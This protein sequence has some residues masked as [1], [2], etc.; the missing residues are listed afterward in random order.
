ME[1]PLATV[2]TSDSVA[3][4][5]AGITAPCHACDR[6][7]RKIRNQQHGRLL[8]DDDP[9]EYEAGEVEEYEGG[10]ADNGVDDAYGDNGYETP[11]DPYDNDDDEGD[12]GDEGGFTVAPVD[13]PVIP[14]DAPADGGSGIPAPD[15]ADEAAA[16]TD[17]A[18]EEPASG[19]DGTDAAAGD[20]APVDGTTTDTGVAT[21]TA[22]GVAV[23]ADGTTAT[24][25]GVDA[26]DTGSTGTFE[27]TPDSGGT[28]ATSSIPAESAP[29]TFE[30]PSTAG[31]PGETSGT[32]A[33]D[34]PT[35]E[36]PAPDTDA[37]INSTDSTDGSSGSTVL[38][39]D[40][41]GTDTT[42]DGTDTT[43]RSS[44]SPRGT[45]GQPPGDVTPTA[46][47]GSGDASADASGSVPQ[48]SNT[49]GDNSTVYAV[50]GTVVAVILVMATL[51]G[52]TVYRRYRKQRWSTSVVNKPVRSPQH[53]AL[54]HP[55][56]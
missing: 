55:I 33:T 40:A 16:G 18:G 32:P 27:G 2:T 47:P 24:D 8:L 11:D 54:R 41:T 38:P 48:V 10:E 17:P 20:A 28:E 45:A 42:Q 49:G 1:F 19:A 3:D 9:E 22:A 37:P 5:T 43:D 30:G 14:P 4:T 56:M 31:V 53:N 35:S 39:D 21:D 6:F 29:S 51:L 23:P 34:I 15:T 46:P 26:A 7:T 25:T 50:V 12:E 52:A 44:A 36:A 13:P